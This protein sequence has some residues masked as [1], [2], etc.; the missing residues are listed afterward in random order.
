VESTLENK[1]LN[2]YKKDMI[3]F[4]KAHPEYFEEA[5]ELAVA[6]KQPYSWRA[7]YVLWSVI[8]ENDKR[9]QKH[10]KKIVNAVKTKSNGHQR[11]LL[12]ILLM[13]DLDEKYESVVFDICMNV[14]E[15]I[16]K[17]PAVRVNA[18]KM[19][20]KIANKHPELRQEIS[21]LTQDHFLES[22]SPGARHSALRL[23]EDVIQ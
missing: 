19:I 13:M 5:I 8:E 23:I 3:S 18:L 20:I 11:E 21:F 4:M 10:I 1:L 16:N 9:I 12:K 22:L 6:N 7:A 2:S 15:Q 14:W 17:A